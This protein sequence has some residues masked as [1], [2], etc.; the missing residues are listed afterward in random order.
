MKTTLTILLC[1]ISLTGFTQAGEKNFID[2]NYIEVTG[3]A[4]MEITPDEIYLKIIVDEKDNKG[5]ES[6][7]EIEKQMIKKFREIGI[8]VSK[9][10][11]IKDFASNFKFYFLKEDKIYTSKEYQ[12]ITHDAKTAGKVFLE[13]EK[14]GVSNISIDRV[15]HSKIEEFR[16]EVKI[17]AMQAAKN[18]AGSLAQAIGQNIG[19]AIY[20]QEFE[21][22]FYPMQGKLAGVSNIMIRGASAMDAGQESLPEVE[23]EKIKLE[24]SIL[25]RFILE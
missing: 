19:K 12:L 22:N 11:S 14:L 1:V 17:K 21:N 13:L 6:V 4:E 20:I 16:N 7:E 23:F 24:Y 18:K 5:K 8:D 10:L 9:E 2:Q 25:S 3:K 15:D